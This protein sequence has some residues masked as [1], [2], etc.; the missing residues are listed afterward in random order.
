MSINVK[1]DEFD[2]KDVFTWLL[3]H[4]LSN[5]THIYTQRDACLYHFA[6]T[7]VAGAVAIYFPIYLRSRLQ[8]HPKCSEKWNVDVKQRNRVNCTSPYHT[9][10]TLHIYADIVHYRKKNYFID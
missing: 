1:F 2:S 3:L 6:A 4:G 7:V 5:T 10:Y 9:V 8:V